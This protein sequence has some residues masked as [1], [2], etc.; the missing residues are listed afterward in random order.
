MN[1]QRNS[2]DDLAP[3]ADSTA[4]ETQHQTTQPPRADAL[5]TAQGESIQDELK[6]QATEA[7]EAARQR[8]AEA[9]AQA[10]ETGRQYA[11]EKKAL[12]AEEVGV[13]S[14]A[15][16]KAS[17]KLHEE[18]HDSIACYVDAAAEQL[19]QFRGSLQD[20]TVGEL[21]DEVQ[22]LTRR[23]PEIV[24][25]GLFVAGLAAMRF[26]KASAPPRRR[27]AAGQANQRMPT[28]YGHAPTPSPKIPPATL[29]STS[30][31]YPTA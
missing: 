25:G 5:E 16:R 15:I 13:L 6:T 8:V 10:K 17:D 21:V 28:A 7:A 30:S 26:L 31:P 9:S 4:S 22:A 12:L 1:P 19:D 18:E 11:S 14:S 3:I 2:V 24:Y 29:K 23:R 27:S 20:M